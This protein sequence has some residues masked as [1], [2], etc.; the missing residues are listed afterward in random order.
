MFLKGCLEIAQNSGFWGPF[1][2]DHAFSYNRGMIQKVVFVLSLFFVSSVFAND[3]QSP[4]KDAATPPAGMD[5][6]DNVPSSCQ[7]MMLNPDGV[8]YDVY[9]KANPDLC[10][11]QDCIQFLKKMKENE[12]RQKL[13][14]SIE[15][16]KGT[17]FDENKDYIQNRRVTKGNTNLRDEPRGK[18]IGTLPDNTMVLLL[19]KSGNWYYVRGYWERTCETGWTYKDNIM[20]ETPTQNGRKR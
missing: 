12:A 17:R 6:L 9:Y 14:K 7:G 18:V 16:I 3:P 10:K 2:K 1:P 8:P 4:Q 19:G 20:E 13:P 5:F 11:D 15:K